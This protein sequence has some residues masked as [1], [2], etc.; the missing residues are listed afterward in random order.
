MNILVFGNGSLSVAQ[1][2]RKLC[3]EFA[4]KGHTVHLLTTESNKLFNVGKLPKHDNLIIY[5][6]PYGQYR[7]DFLPVPDDIDV[8]LGM[9]Q[10]VS[11]FVVEY[12]KRTGKRAYCMFLDFPVHVIDSGGSDYNFD[13]S[14]RYYYWIMCGLELDGIIFNNTVAVEEFYKRYKKE[15]H[16]VWYAVSNDDCYENYAGTED[17]ENWSKD[18]AQGDYIAGL[19]RII[20][21]KGVHHMME[22]LKYLDYDYLHGFVSG[23]PK[24]MEE[25]YSAAKKLPQNVTFFEKNGEIEKMRLL[26]GAKVVVYPQITEWIG[27]MSIIEAWSV[28]TPGVCFDYPVLKELYGDCALYAKPGDPISLADKVNTLMTDNDMNLEMARN[29][30]DRFKKHF[31]KEV[32]A[33]NILEVIL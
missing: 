29:G 22:A 18:H 21:Y 17:W 4:K 32:M 25:V 12:K 11:Q 14:Q 33:Q 16:L 2:E 9:D 8:A 1:Q 10:S 19:N 26:Y 24:Y 6:L 13:Y 7:Y 31:T 20:K 28:K 30:Y 5:D 3:V 15:S 27:G 23:D